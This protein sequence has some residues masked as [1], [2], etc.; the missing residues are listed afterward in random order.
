MA[1]CFLDTTLV[2]EFAEKSS[3]AADWGDDHLKEH[4]PAE[5]PFYALRELLAGKVSYLCDAHNRLQAAETLPEALRAFSRMPSVVGR[6]RDVPLQALIDELTNVYPGN[7]GATLDELKR[8]ML[9]SLALRIARLWNNARKSKQYSVIQHLACFSGGKLTRDA[10]NALRGPGDSFGCDPS[11]RCAAAAYI[12]DD[13]AALGSMVNAL[14]PTSLGALA[15]KNENKQRRVALK[16]LKSQGPER[17]SKKRCRALGDAYFAAMC[18]PGS[19]VVTT[20]AA[21]HVP[22]CSALGKSVVSPS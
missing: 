20:N 21:D 7:P 19:H 16:E 17:F 3:L 9:Q 12:Y 5:A 11:E 13:Q 18:P 10:A 6:R 1:G 4:T 8:E 14:H 15:E 22:L 2:V